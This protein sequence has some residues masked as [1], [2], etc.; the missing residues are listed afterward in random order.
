MRLNYSLDY[1]VFTNP[2]KLEP[3]FQTRGR[4]SCYRVLTNPT[5]LEPNNYCS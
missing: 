4:Q 3:G 5:K 2:T 1:R